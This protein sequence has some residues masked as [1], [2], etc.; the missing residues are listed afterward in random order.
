MATE[1]LFA[2]IFE[3]LN[4]PECAAILAAFVFQV[5]YSLTFGILFR[6]TDFKIY[7]LGKN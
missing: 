1:A 2:N 4:P 3:P 7:Y 5:C 6:L